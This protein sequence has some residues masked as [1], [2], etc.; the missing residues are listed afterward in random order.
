MKRVGN[1]YARRDSLESVIRC[2]LILPKS[3]VVDKAR[4]EWVPWPC[5]QHVVR[6]PDGVRL[7]GGEVEVTEEI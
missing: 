1:L 3:E 5:G 6:K 4:R 2:Y 7:W